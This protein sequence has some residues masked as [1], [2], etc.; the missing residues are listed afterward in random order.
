MPE[1]GLVILRVKCPRPVEIDSGA[2]MYAAHGHQIERRRL[3]RLATLQGVVQCPSD[4]GADA[5]AADLGSA[6]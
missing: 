3:Q 5:E 4:E 2:R 1:P 6:S